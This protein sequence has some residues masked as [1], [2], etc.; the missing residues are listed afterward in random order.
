[1]VTSAP[2][3]LEQPA[4]AAASAI[5]MHEGVP[6]NEHA[7]FDSS[8][9]SVALLHDQVLN[10]YRLPEAFARTGERLDVCAQ[11]SAEA[12]FDITCTDSQYPQWWAL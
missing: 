3:R 10:T 11:R 6:S 1:L 7:R 5:I 8:L 2:F 9:F 12:A 4:L